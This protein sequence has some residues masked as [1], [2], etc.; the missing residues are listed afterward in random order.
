MRIAIAGAGAVGTFM[1]EDLA[2]NGHEVT[3][4]ERDPATAK[5][6]QALL[7]QVAVRVVDACEISSL[8][9]VQ[10]DKID[11]MVAA[12]GD[13]EDNLVVSLIAKQEFAVPR[14]VARVNNPKNHWMFN[15][16]WGVDVA[17]STPHQLTAMVEEAVSSGTL[18]KLL[19]LGDSD[20]ALE[21]VTLA[22][23]SPV[24]G[25]LVSEIEIPRNAT[26]VAIVRKRQV[27]VPHGDTR[28]VEG[29]EVIVLAT[30]SS[31]GEIKALLIGPK[32]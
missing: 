23:S 19:S 6:V 11:V 7:P 13:D 12:T 27:I 31:E 32:P 9:S 22:A 30:N 10:L 2:S 4:L 28:L 15:M 29:D 25:K 14:V 20:V 8:A 5:R 21:E 24:V 17:V 16:S 3:L 1:A 18:V 26:M